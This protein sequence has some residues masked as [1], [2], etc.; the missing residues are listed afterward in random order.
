MD[1]C[2]DSERTKDKEGGYEGTGRGEGEDHWRKRKGQREAG[3]KDKDQQVYL[4]E[5]KMAH[6]NAGCKGPAINHNQIK[7]RSDKMHMCRR[8]GILSD[9]NAPGCP[10]PGSRN[11]LSLWLLY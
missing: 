1:T 2:E 8:I 9:D 4:I 6:W 3:K 7:G 11:K 10:A 5:K